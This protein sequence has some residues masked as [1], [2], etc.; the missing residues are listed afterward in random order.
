[1]KE[2]SLFSWLDFGAELGKLFR[3]YWGSLRSSNAPQ[4]RVRLLSAFSDSLYEMSETA[5][6]RFLRRKPSTWVWA[7]LRAF[8]YY[9]M[10]AVSDVMW[11]L[12]RERGV[13][14]E[15]WQF[16]ARARIKRKKGR[17]VDAAL[18]TRIA[19]HASP[20]RLSAYALFS[21]CMIEDTLILDGARK[22]EW[23]FLKA[24][25]L[26]TEIV[27]LFRDTEPEQ[28]ILAL[29]VLSGIS[30]RVGHPV[31]AGAYLDS[32]REIERKH[33]L[34]RAELLRPLEEKLRAAGVLD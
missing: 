29:L 15:P 30:L 1:M 27:P 26:V 5:N 23:A 25:Q 9:R 2:A 34:S 31:S 21:A 19:L 20:P 24:H 7:F 12:S 28:A 10:E 16:Y 6:G 11:R 33:N 18:L 22:N 32:A 13:K 8:C 17:L 4:E 3:L 14:L